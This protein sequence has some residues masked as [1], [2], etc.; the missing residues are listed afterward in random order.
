M[1]HST[2]FTKTSI[3]AIGF[4]L[5]FVFVLSDIS[6][7]QIAKEDV[8]DQV[9]ASK[10]K[11]G[12][13]NKFKGPNRETTRAINF[14][15]SELQSILDEYKA[16]GVSTITFVPALI[17]NEDVDRYVARNPGSQQFKNQIVNRQT[18]LIKAPQN[19]S[20][21][22]NG[23]LNA[24]VKYYDIGTICPPPLSCIE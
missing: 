17:R 7:A 4:L 16:A 13:H 2:S 9:N 24:A 3:K 18:L 22:L 20:A 5:L 14:S 12:F 8:L 10:R 11:E 23:M 19:G 15:V 6:L 21:S 1:Q